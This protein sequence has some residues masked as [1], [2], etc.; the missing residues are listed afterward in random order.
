MKDQTFK[1]ITLMTGAEVEMLLCRGVHLAKAQY[2]HAQ[3]Q[4]DPNAEKFE[5]TIYLMSE[6]CLVN[7]EKKEIEYFLEL[8][9]DDF[10]KIMN[11]MNDIL[12][13]FNK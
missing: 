2:R 9:C 6:L 7:G 5:L 4:A 8:M 10:M 13:D 3:A 11:E 12:T 1:K